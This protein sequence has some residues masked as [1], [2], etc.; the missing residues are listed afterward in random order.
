MKRK[1]AF[2]VLVLLL[3]YSFVFTAC[4]QKPPMGGWNQYAKS[5]REQEGY[6]IVSG[7]KRHYWLYDTYKYHDGDGLVIFTHIIPAWVEMMGYVIDYDNI[8]EIDPNTDL[9]PSVKSLMKQRD[10]DISVTLVT[11]LSYDYVIINDYDKKANIYRSTI[12]PFLEEEDYEE[13]HT[14]MSVAF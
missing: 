13:G 7:V 14:E 10:C 8:Q 5:Y 11:D 2:G 9:A 4:D 12:Y 6:A 1:T 3:I